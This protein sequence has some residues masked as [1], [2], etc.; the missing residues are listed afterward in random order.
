MP[1]GWACSW[2]FALLFAFSRSN[3][4]VSFYVSG[5]K[6]QSSN[7]RCLVTCCE[8]RRAYGFLPR[9][10]EPRLVKFCAQHKVAGQIN[11]MTYRCMTANCAKAA[12]FAPADGG[13]AQRCGA[14]RMADDVDVRSRSKTCA[15]PECTTQGSFGAGNGTKDLFCMAHR[16]AAGA[17]RDRKNRPC[18]QVGC[19][20]RA[21][22]WR[23]G[24]LWC[25]VHCGPSRFNIRVKLSENDGCVQAASRGKL[26]PRQEKTRAGLVAA[27]ADP[28]DNPVVRASVCDPHAVEHLIRTGRIQ[29]VSRAQQSS[30]LWRRR[31]MCALIAAFFSADVS[32][33]WDAGVAVGL[34]GGR[35]LAAA[36]Q[37][38]GGK[39]R[40]TKE[41]LV[42]GWLQIGLLQTVACRGWNVVT[43]STRFAV[44]FGEETHLR[45]CAAPVLW[46]PWWQ[47]AGPGGG[48]EE[49][50]WG[51]V[52]PF[53]RA[54]LREHLL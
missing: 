41:A 46:Q 7:S 28:C 51:C 13:R 49:G 9:P 52:L 32:G 42:E 21:S 45:E 4:T 3:H 18:K 39:R 37:V 23:R 11:L 26:A 47:Q 22:C 16:E 33:A 15:F 44:P 27:R 43:E 35:L 5:S 29:E 2:A 1:F 10:G 36:E 53:A 19:H 17:V 6:T 50:R 54:L 25:R 12:S 20:R 14:H 31:R 30:W 40:P 38:L 34:R 8:R 24:A 48:G